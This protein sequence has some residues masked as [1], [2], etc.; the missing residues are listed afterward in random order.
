MPRAG[1]SVTA[2]AIGEATIGLFKVNCPAFIDLD[3][4]SA[5]IVQQPEKYRWSPSVSTFK[6]TTRITYCPQILVLKNLMSQPRKTVSVAIAEYMYKAGAIDRPDKGKSKVIDHRLLAE[7]KK[8][9]S[10]ITKASRLRYRTRY[11]T[12]SGIFQA[13]L[14]RGVWILTEAQQYPTAFIHHCHVYLWFVLIFM[15]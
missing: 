11:F 2:A 13:L 14:W 15:V 10:E 12:D 5:G 7:A 9:G 1:K 6:P 8:K 3:P 4:M